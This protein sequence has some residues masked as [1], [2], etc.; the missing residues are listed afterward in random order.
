MKIVIKATNFSL[1]VSLRNYVLQK[2]G[3]DLEKFVSGIHPE[4]TAWVEIAK[5]T[6]HHHKGKIFRAEMQMRPPGDTSIRAEAE[7][8]DL[9][10]AIDRVRDII[11]SE[12]KKYKTRQSALTK[13]RARKIK[14]DLKLSSGARFWRKGRIREEGI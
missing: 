1:T 5:T 14:K 2:L 13:R 12:C 3:R 10:T 6:T 4:I 7:D 9:H 8:T 11:A